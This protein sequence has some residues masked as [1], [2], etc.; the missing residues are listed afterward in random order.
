MGL[1]E[2]S[3][4]AL[5]DLGGRPLAAHSLAVFEAS[6]AVG[7]VVL[8]APPGMSP[9]FAG[10]LIQPGGFEKVSAIVDGGRTRQVSVRIGLDALDDGFDPVLIH[11]A[12]RPLLLPGIVAACASTAAAVGA[13]VPATPV[14]NTVKSITADG[15]VE[16]TL[17]R[18]KLREVQTPQGFRASLIR[19]AHLR[20]AADGVEG[21]DDAVLVEGLGARVAVLEGDPENLKVTRPVDL[22]LARILLSRRDGDTSH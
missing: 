1:E 6:P 22:E 2:G 21:T 3:P 15:I 11:D 14:L 4:K 18:E 20:A 8:V 16:K 12:A 10:E 7:S 17:D 9:R 13:C 5:L 19:D